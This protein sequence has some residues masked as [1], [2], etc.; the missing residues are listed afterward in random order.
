MIRSST[1]CGHQIISDQGWNLL[2]KKLLTRVGL[3]TP[4]L[5]EVIRILG[6][7]Y[8]ETD[9]V[10]LLNKCADFGTRRFYL[11]VGILQQNG[12]LMFLQKKISPFLNLRKTYKW[13][14]QSRGT[15]CRLATAML[16]WAKEND[17][18]SAV[19]H[20]GKFLNDYILKKFLTTKCF[21]N[22][23]LG[24]AIFTQCFGRPT[25]C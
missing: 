25:N 6:P 5:D 9:A 14:Q 11:K 23:F 22:Q 8:S 21:T 19:E 4:N 15:G 16:F 17:L 13:R 12:V 20:A 2:L 10:K 7:E 3:V 24:G 1:S 18:A